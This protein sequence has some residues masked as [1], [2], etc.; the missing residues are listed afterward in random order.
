MGSKSACCEPDPACLL[1]DDPTLAVCCRRDLQEQAY[2]NRLREKL[3]TLDRSNERTKLAQ[4]AY[5]HNAEHVPGV[6]AFERDSLA[7]DSDDDDPGKSRLVMHVSAGLTF[8]IVYSSQYKAL[9]EVQV[10][11][12]REGSAFLSFRHREESAHLPLRKALGRLWTLT[13]QIYR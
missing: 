13:G 6:A 12:R 3:L 8:V 9:L 11:R 4:G 1:D 7:T 2:N 5:A 10:L